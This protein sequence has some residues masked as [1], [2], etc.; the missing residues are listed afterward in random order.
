MVVRAGEEHE[1]NVLR[2]EGGTDWGAVGGANL[3]VE[4]GRGNAAVDR[5]LQCRLEIVRG[6]DLGSRIAQGVR[7]AQGDQRFVIHDKDRV[8]P[9]RA[10]CSPHAA[11]THER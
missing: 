8:S 5:G 6:Y 1:R 2:A 11:V 10:H 9:K 3:Y 7:D 4:N